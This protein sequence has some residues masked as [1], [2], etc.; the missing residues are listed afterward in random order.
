[1]DAH[2]CLLH[3][4]LDALCTDDTNDYYRCIGG[5]WYDPALDITASHHEEKETHTDEQITPIVQEEYMHCEGCGLDVKTL[6]DGRCAGC[7]IIGDKAPQGWAKEQLREAIRSG[8]ELAVVK[9]VQK[10]SRYLDF[11]EV[12]QIKYEEA[13]LK[14][15][16]YL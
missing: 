11:E 10:A 1:M 5:G 12:E 3:V 6:I 7:R 2:R 9:A 13:V 15:Q 14:Q 4:A 8:N 16:E